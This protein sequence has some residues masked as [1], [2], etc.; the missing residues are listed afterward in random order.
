MIVML[1]YYIYNITSTNIKIEKFTDIEMIT[2]N[3]LY[4]KFYANIYDELFYS[5][6]KV[7]HET[8]IIK[9]TLKKSSTILDLGCGTGQHISRL[10][11][12][13]ITGLDSSNAMLQI[14]KKKAPNIRYKLGDANNKSL[15]DFHKFSDILVLYFVIYYQE[16]ISNV[17]ENCYRWLK[18]GGQLIIHLVNP[19][20]FDPILNP[21]SP[22]PGFSVQKYSKKR[23]TK[24]NVYFNN[25]EYEGIF[26]LDI[27]NNEAQFIETFKFKDPNKLD[28]TQ[29][30]K[31]YIPSIPKMVEV[32]KKAGFEYKK[33]IDLVICGYEY[34]YLYF[35]TKK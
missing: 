22:F 33:N 32:I 11:N 16:N 17:L 14:A 1:T 31:L 35:F 25:F 26:N 12:Y 24:S 8:N 23:I 20:K 7:S 3:N 10:K 30:H 29:K 21:A 13:N 27:E 15:F 9:N 2:G 5:E 18:R 34:Q 28:R 6:P 19:E 4:D